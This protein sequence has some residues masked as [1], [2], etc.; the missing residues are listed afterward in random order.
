MEQKLHPLSPDCPKWIY[1]SFMRIRAKQ[2][3]PKPI[4]MSEI[5]IEACEYNSEQLD[6][7]YEHE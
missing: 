6:K 7:Q 4:S 5:T 1:D 2:K 3:T